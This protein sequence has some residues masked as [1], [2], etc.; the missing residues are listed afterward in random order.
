MKYR[1]AVDKMNTD[2]ME[3]LEVREKVRA[4][5]AELEPEEVEDY[6]FATP[7]G[8]VR[9]SDL[10]GDKDTLFVV[11]N[12][13]TGCIYC[14]IWADGL[15]GVIGHLEDR[16][17]FVVSSPDSPAKQQEFAR[18]R[19]WTLPMVSHAGTSFAQDMGY[20][21]DDGY[22]PGVS[23]FRR[24]GTK[25]LRVSDTMFGPGDTFCAVW[26]LFDMIPEGAGDWQPR[27]SYGQ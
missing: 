26:H 2:R 3:I 7:E 18:S 12:M 14:T 23:V 22:L 15:N 1:E 19:G 17:A 8:A 25:V 21:S 4:V 13:G 27:Y 11:H 10:F 20:R 5:Q 16:A 6:A 9:L 24:D